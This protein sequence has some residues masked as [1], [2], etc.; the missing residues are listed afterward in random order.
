MSKHPSRNVQ[1]FSAVNSNFFTNVTFQ[2]IDAF[3]SARLQDLHIVIF[4]LIYKTFL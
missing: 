1:S 3:L 2:T 4:Q